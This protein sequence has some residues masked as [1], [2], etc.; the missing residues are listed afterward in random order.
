M[1][2]TAAVLNKHD[3]LEAIPYFDNIL[4]KVRFEVFIKRLIWPS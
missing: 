3:I 4:R 1:K 2:V